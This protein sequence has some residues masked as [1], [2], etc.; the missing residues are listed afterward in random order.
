MK[1]K[2]P[3]PRS[4]P[5]R[6]KPNP[7]V[8]HV[9]DVSDLVAEIAALRR[10]VKRLEVLAKMQDA[11]VKSASSPEPKSTATPGVGAVIR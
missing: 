4:A 9:V 5:K 1:R 3:L 10:R 8:L 2:A 7:V 11:V 6:R